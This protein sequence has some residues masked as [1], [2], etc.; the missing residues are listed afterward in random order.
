MPH[1]GL[2]IPRMNNAICSAVFAYA[3]SSS[4][5]TTFPNID[6]FTSSAFTIDT[7]RLGPI[8]SHHSTWN[9]A[10][11]M[12]PRQC[13]ETETHKN[14]LPNDYSGN[15]GMHQ[16]RVTHRDCETDHEHFVR[17]GV[18]KRSE[19][20]ALVKMA[21]DIAVAEVQRTCKSER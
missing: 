16:A 12:F 19:S 8:R 9:T 17:H 21:C 11:A 1:N 7:I 5:H 3:I 10:I 2:H 15:R 14:V 18:D 13:K 4:H 20:T 6:G